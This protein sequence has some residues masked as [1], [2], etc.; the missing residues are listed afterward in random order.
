MLRSFEPGV[1]KWVGFPRPSR[2]F[3]ESGFAALQIFIDF[4]PMREV[5]SDPA[6]SLRQRQRRIGLNDALRRLALKE[7][8]DNRLERYATAG[9][10]I[11]APRCSMNSWSTA[12][13][14]CSFAR[15]DFCRRRCISKS[16]FRAVSARANR[17]TQSRPQAGGRPGILQDDAASGICSGPPRYGGVTRWS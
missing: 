12:S 16:T 7:L 6:V 5:V 9:E 2:Q 14:K 1:K 3:F 8:I 15:R 13:I 4:G 11:T 17:F 10:V